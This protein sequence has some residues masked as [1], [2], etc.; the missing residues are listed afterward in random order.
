M[1]TLI[2]NV[3]AQE[4]APEEAAAPKPSSPTLAVL[5]FQD[6]TQDE[7]QRQVLDCPALEARYGDCLERVEFS[8]VDWLWEQQS[9]TP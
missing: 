9:S 3:L 7:D 2:F 6:A 5:S 8:G 1:L 4:A